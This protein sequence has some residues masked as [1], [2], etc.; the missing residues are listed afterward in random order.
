[1]VGIHNNIGDYFPCY[2]T[3]LYFP[4]VEHYANKF[5]DDPWKLTLG[6]KFVTVTQVLWVCKK[7]PT[8]DSIMGTF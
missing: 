6:R 5:E 8:H 3:P 1:M 4:V 7:I 2:C